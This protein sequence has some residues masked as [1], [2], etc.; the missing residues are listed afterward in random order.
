[1]ATD[2]MHCMDAKPLLTWLLRDL[3]KGFAF[4][5]PKELFFR[6]EKSDPFRMERYGKT[7]ETPVG[8]AAGPHTQMAH[9]II[10][11]WLCGARYMELK[12]VQVLDAIT[13][14][15]PC[16]EMGDEGYNCEWSQELNLDGSYR[17]Y[18]KAWV[19][20]HILHDHLGFPGKPG[21]LFNMSAGYS[22]EGILSPTM[23]RFLDRMQGSPDE[24]EAL[25]RELEPLYPRVMHLDIPGCISDNLTISCMHGCPPEEVEKISLYFIQDRKLNTTLKLNPTLLGPA[26][27]RKLVNEVMGY[28]T[29]IPDLAFE[30]DLSYDTTLG[31]L[32]TCLDA[33]KNIGVRFGVKLT[34]T[35]ETLNKGCLPGSEKMLYMSG[36]PLH[37]IAVALAA[38]LQ[39]DFAGKLDISFCAGADALNVADTLACGLMPVTVCS[40][41]LKP[42]GYGRL[43]QYFVTIREAMAATGAANLAD[44]I[45]KRAGSSSGEDA[46][47]HNLDVYA[48]ELALPKSRYARSHAASRGIKTERPLPVLDCAAA[49]CVSACPAGQDIPAYLEQAARGRLDE[50]LA[51]IL[52]T[53]PFPSVLGKVCNQEC[54]NRCV[55]VHYDTPLQIRAVKGCAAANGSA[56]PTPAAPNGRNV[57]IIGAGPVGLSCAHFLAL[58]GC[59]VSVYERRDTA[60]GTTMSKLVREK[61]NVERDIAAILKLGVSI[62]TNAALDAEAVAKLVEENDAVHLA[63]RG[64]SA[65]FGMD[66]PKLFRSAH[67]QGDASISI[68]ASVGE[69]RRAA[70]QI[71]AF[72]DVTSGLPSEPAR[73]ATNVSASVRR[74]AFRTPNAKG[75]SFFAAASGAAAIAASIEEAARCLQCDRYCGI[76]VSVCPNRANLAV[77]GPERAW[78]IQ[79]AVRSGDETIVR[80]LGVKTL[81]QSWQV[82]NIG[83]FC[84]ECGNCE[85]FC[86]S[87]GAPYKVKERVHFGEASFKAD[88]NGF[89]RLGNETFAGKRANEP[90]SLSLGPEGWQ[91]E[92]D[93]VSALLDAQTLAAKRVAL[94]QGVNR[95]NLSDAAQAVILCDLMRGVGPLEA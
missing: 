58:A 26:H 40:D 82:L 49:P 74:Q 36:K 60:G 46:V 91:Y 20:I 85:T 8:A 28:E 27:V 76:C 37:P 38:K 77:F 80:T 55:R 44:F 73:A 68:V 11:A 39:K 94:K 50:A 90:W 88:A 23:Q 61:D 7:L 3:E 47:R 54:R 12:T 78:P 62:K 51:V 21:L 72:M 57:A 15:K 24:V 64:D 34:N 65:V 83:D 71:L 69:G 17:E 79:E 1:M 63:V 31:I 43:A 41:L 53:N 29:Q 56:V 86:P 16:I 35:L 4:G 13:V 84:N 32:R 30:H 6:P 33:A 81:S 10:A 59:K 48:A 2:H 87:S 22:M 92:D 75:T 66:M 52:A 70:G 19:L 45:R 93:R 5:I 95:A 14:T 89:I 42:G 18:L 9:N 25:K 67:P